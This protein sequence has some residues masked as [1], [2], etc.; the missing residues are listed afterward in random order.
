[1]NGTVH[2]IAVTHATYENV[3]TLAGYDQQRILS[4]IY[5]SKRKGDSHREG[6][7]H[8]GCKPVL[9]EDGMRFDVGDTGNA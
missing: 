3:V 8:P 5:Q 2:Q 1:V 4:V 6:I 9:L 7:M